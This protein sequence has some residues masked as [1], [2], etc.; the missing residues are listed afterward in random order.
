MSDVAD[1]PKQER[2]KIPKEARHFVRKPPYP[3]K[4]LKQ[5]YPEK[6]VVPTFSCFDSRKGNTLVHVSKFIDSMGPY[7]NNGDLY[8]H[9][10]SKS[11]NDK[12]YTWYTTLPPGSVRSWEYIV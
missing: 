7:V 4:L 2:E 6:Y 3:A 8:L 5:P 12:A 10:F 9:E 11:L 1:L